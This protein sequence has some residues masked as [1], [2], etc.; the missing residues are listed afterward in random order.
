LL[1]LLLPLMRY[2]KT[3]KIWN[4]NAP[5]HCRSDK[6]TTT[7]VRRTPMEVLITPR[8]SGLCIVR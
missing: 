3:R 1:L 2:R 8:E 6:K 4:E 5:E 7:G